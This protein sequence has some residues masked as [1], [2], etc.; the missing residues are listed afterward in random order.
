MSALTSLLV[1]VDRGTAG[2]FLEIMD[3]YK[4]NG[5]AK[6]LIQAKANEL[7]YYQLGS[8]STQTY[9]MLLTLHD[10]VFEYYG[11]EFEAGG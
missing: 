4:I 6:W 9:A 2:H 5:F 7:G 8:L 3:T 1:A 10:E 11:L